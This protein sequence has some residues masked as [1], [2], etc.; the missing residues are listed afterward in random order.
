MNLKTLSPLLL[1]L[2]IAPAFA[3]P[4]H[5]DELPVSVKQE[6]TKKSA[7]AKEDEHG[8][9]LEEAKAAK[10]AAGKKDEHGHSHDEAKAEKKTA[11]A[12]AKK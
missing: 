5:D 12:P 8:H 10:K 6:A 7:S 9:T 2:F 4:T 3:H 11:A 1:S